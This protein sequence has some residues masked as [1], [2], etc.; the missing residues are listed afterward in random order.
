MAQER[1]RGAR[2]LSRRYGLRGRAVVVAALVL[3]SVAAVLALAVVPTLMGDAVVVERASEATET[4]AGTGA[5]EADGGA[6]DEPATGA[7][8]DEAAPEA[9]VVH[10]DGAVAVP[11]VYEL[12]AGARV[13]DAVL[14][15]GGLVEGA[16]TSSLNLAAPLADGEKVHVPREGETLAPGVSDEAADDATTGPI[17][18][19][20]ATAEELDALPGV[21]EATA[22]AIVE[23]REANGPFTTPEDL[24]RVSGIGEKKFERIRGLVCV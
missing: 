19:N 21:G 10:V 9:L 20:A 15:A 23:D 17:N 1:V 5:G 11:G 13:N 16:D 4:D 2:G 14:A 12:G 24:M 8:A 3:V 22:R 6:G 18:L 7:D